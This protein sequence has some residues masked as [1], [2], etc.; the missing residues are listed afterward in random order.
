[1]LGDG[2][3][4]AGLGLDGRTGDY[5]RQ[6]VHIGSFYLY[7]TA[8]WHAHSI[9]KMHESWGAGTVYLIGGILNFVQLG[10]SDWVELFAFGPYILNRDK[11]CYRFFSICPR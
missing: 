7:S 9:Y 5:S 2:D 6:V 4:R 3:L 11:C 10:V 8:L 1:M